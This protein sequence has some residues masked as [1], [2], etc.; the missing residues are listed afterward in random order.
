MVFLKSD[1]VLKD[2]GGSVPQR[3]PQYYEETLDQHSSSCVAF[4]FYNIALIIKKVKHI[5]LR[6]SYARR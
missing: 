2:Q 1:L 6:Q 4:E 5:Y 3:L